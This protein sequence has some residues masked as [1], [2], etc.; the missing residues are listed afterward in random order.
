[1]VFS[2]SI[3]EKFENQ[4]RE[5]AQ[6]KSVIIANVAKDADDH[7][8]TPPVGTEL[9]ADDGGDTTPGKNA[10]RKKGSHGVGAN[11]PMPENDLVSGKGG[12]GK[13]RGLKNK[14]AI[15]GLA[16]ELGISAPKSTKT[17]LSSKGGIAASEDDDIFSHEDLAAKILEW[18]PDMNTAGTGK[19][20]SL[21]RGPV[22]PN[23]KL[24]ASLEAI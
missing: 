16:G 15:S 22:S 13:K 19:R 20:F 14:H 3:I 12:K 23:L 8:G 11:K 18:Y 6:K 4:A 7:P 10:R 2:Q 5:L 9:D 17:S 1:M 24:F 21:L